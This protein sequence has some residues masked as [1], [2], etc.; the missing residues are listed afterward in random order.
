LFKY[1]ENSFLSRALITLWG[2]VDVEGA[3]VQ[4]SMAIVT[5]STEVQRIGELG[6]CSSYCWSGGWK[7]WR[8]W[9]RQGRC[10]W[11]GQRGGIS[12]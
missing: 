10:V 6:T 2:Q 1:T 9:H 4:E 11:Y 12:Y 5:F 7:H 8:R 3:E